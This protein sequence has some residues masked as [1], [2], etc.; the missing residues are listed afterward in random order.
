MPARE[1]GMRRC[2]ACGSEVPGDG[3][4]FRDAD[5]AACG[6]DLRCCRNCR[7]HHPS[8]NNQ[9]LEPVAEW[10]ADKE[11]ANFCDYF[12]FADSTEAASGEP[13]KSGEEAARAKW[14]KLFKE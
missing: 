9:C 11:R 7:H 12:S 2:H 5:C 3:R 6:R 13:R 4:V 1:V 8:A 10:V 14:K